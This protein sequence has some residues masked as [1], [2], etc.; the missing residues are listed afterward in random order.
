MLRKAGCSSPVVAAFTEAEIKAG[1]KH[2]AKVTFDNKVKASCRVVDF[3][4]GKDRL[5]HA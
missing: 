4:V 3:L 5:E 1:V 2:D